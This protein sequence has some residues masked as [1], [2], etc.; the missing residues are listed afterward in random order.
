MRVGGVN[1]I[2]PANIS[3]N[4]TNAALTNN[5]NLSTDTSGVSQ[6]SSSQSV[7]Q[8]DRPIIGELNRQFINVPLLM[9]MMMFHS[10]LLFALPLL[11][12]T[13]ESRIEKK[14]K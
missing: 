2:L 10:V 1:L 4:A 6:A 13:D 14:C 8:D 7:L 12:M 9:I 3:N 5:N 11:L